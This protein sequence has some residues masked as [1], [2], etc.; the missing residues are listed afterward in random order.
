MNER[1]IQL[2]EEV[3]RKLSVMIALLANPIE[4]GSKVLLRDQI[5]MLDSF[6]LKPSEIASILNKTPNHVSKELAVQRKGK[7]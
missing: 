7:R 4:P 5:V 6:G 1:G 2:L 3:S